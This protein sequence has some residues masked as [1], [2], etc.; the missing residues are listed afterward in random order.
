MGSGAEN[1][2]GVFSPESSGL[3]QASH[4]RP[5][6]VAHQKLLVHK[7]QTT[8]E[9]STR[10]YWHY[11][12]GFFPVLFSPHEDLSEYLSDAAFNKP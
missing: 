7:R 9:F 11:L 1:L 10:R 3:Q 12:V 6:F 8:I 4:L 5:Y 2:T